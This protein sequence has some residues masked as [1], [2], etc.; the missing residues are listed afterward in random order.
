[1]LIVLVL[2]M[3]V[4]GV[5]PEPFIKLAQSAGIEPQP[6]TPAVTAARR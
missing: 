3:L 1:M 5:Y 6:S 4:F 2:L